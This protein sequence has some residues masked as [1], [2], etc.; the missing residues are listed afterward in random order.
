MKKVEYEG[1]LVT[2]LSSNSYI[3]FY[4]SPCCTLHVW[5]YPFWPIFLIFNYSVLIIFWEDANRRNESRPSQWQQK[6][7]DYDTSE[8]SQ[9]NCFKIAISKLCTLIN[10]KISLSIKD[11]YLHTI[12]GCSEHQSSFRFWNKKG[13][14]TLENNG[15]QRWKRGGKKLSSATALYIQGGRPTYIQKLSFSID[16]CPSAFLLYLLFAWNKNCS[17][18]F[19]KVWWL[20]NSS[21]LWIF[22]SAISLREAI[23]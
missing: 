1:I 13:R 23:I 9:Q 5:I 20:V 17:P 4:E 19:K 3:R 2:I 11:G 15:F 7:Y 22:C 14:S 12:E 6:E 21:T 18:N 10:C 16:G 8:F